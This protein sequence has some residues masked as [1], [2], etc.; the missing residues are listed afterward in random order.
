MKAKILNTNLEKLEKDNQELQTKFAL[1]KDSSDEELH[2]L[3]KELESLKSGKGFMT[4]LTGLARQQR[5]MA[6][7]LKGL[8]GKKFDFVL[9]RED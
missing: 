1:M 8:T 4:L 7:E 6:E 3:S 2:K 5:Q 9:G